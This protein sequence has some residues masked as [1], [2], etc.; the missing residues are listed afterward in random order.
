MFDEPRLSEAEWAL[1]LELLERERS[2]LPVEIH[3]TR[4][5]DVRGELQQR[6][7]LVRGLLGR[8]RTPMAV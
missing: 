8:L 2:E 3:H 1:V 5:A 4:S 6:A 7:D